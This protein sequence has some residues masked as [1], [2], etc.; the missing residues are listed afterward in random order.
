MQRL[1]E[2]RA[3]RV[4]RFTVSFTVVDAPLDQG[5]RW[6]QFCLPPAATSSRGHSATPG[7]AFGCHNGGGTCVLLT[8]N[9]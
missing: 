5:L 7:D 8:S 3:R 2:E 4:S 9:V 1:G 6:G